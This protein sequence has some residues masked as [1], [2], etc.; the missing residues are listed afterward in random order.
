MFLERELLNIMY[1]NHFQE[2][3]ETLSVFR[4]LDEQTHPFVERTHVNVG[5]I[6]DLFDD[7]GDSV[8]HLLR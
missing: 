2:S 5:V 6:V 7:F 1:K 3:I 4:P 8:D